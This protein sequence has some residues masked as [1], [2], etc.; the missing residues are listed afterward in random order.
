MAVASSAE[1]APGATFIPRHLPQ[2]DERYATD[3]LCC[4]AKST[5]RGL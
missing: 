4:K 1:Q 2:V 3:L 5:G